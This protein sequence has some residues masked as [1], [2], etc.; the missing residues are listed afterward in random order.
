MNDV[1]TR[2]FSSSPCQA[3]TRAA[4]H[5]R[6]PHSKVGDSEFGEKASVQQDTSCVQWTGWAAATFRRTS[7]KYWMA[8]LRFLMEPTR[9]MMAARCAGGETARSC[10]SAACTIPGRLPSSAESSGRATERAV[11]A[12]AVAKGVTSVTATGGSVAGASPLVTASVTSEVN[13]FAAASRF[14][15]GFKSNSR[16]SVAGTDA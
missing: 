8:S 6:K 4:M 1:C 3:Q 14:V 12:D 2:E 5:P 16:S 13:G 11:S 9:A 10:R 15:I 7:F